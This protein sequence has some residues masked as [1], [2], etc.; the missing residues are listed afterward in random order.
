VNNIT[1]RLHA[2]SVS[3]NNEFTDLNAIQLNWKPSPLQWSIAQCIDHIIVSN[4]QYLPA[5]KATV[6]GKYKLTFW[7]KLNPLTKYTGRKM[8]QTLGAEVKKKY[9][10]PKI[11]EPSRSH[12]DQSIIQRFLSH[13]EELIKLFTILENPRFEKSIISSPVAV[14]ITLTIPDVLGIITV[15]EERHLKQA[16]VVIQNEKF[17]K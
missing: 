13:Q 2:I 14:L 9:K 15:H 10:S 16:V 12:I 1:Q 6:S 8:I 7:E 17:P 3:F 11:F 5:L 4:E